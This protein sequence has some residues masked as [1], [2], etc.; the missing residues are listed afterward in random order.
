MTE[1]ELISI[2]KSHRRDSIGVADGEL[3]SERA[4]ALDHYHGR[5]YGNEV[6]G[7]SQVVSR[8]LSETVDWALPTVL[9]TFLQS[10]TL[11]AFDPVGPEDEDAADQEAQYTNH[12]MLKDNNGFM[13][14]HDA[15]KDT[16]I[17]KNGYTKRIWDD[18]EKIEEGE[19]TGLTMDQVVQLIQKKSYGGA[20]VE[21]IGAEVREIEIPGMPA[22]NQAQAI[23]TPPTIE[24][25]DLRLRTKCKEGKLLWMA[26]PTEEIRVSKKC[27]GT[28]Q[29]SPFTEHVTKKTRTD[30]I[31]MGMDEDFVNSLPAFNEDDNDSEKYARDSVTDESDS[32]NG[33]SINDRSMD[34]IEFC[35]AYIKVDWDK[36]GRAE[37]RKVVTV[38]DR[39]PP[40]SQWNEQIY[41]VPITGYSMKRVPHRHVGESF[42]DELKDLQEIFTTLKRQLND[43]VYFSNAGEVVINELA[44]VKDFMTR[45]P[46]GLKRTKGTS[47]PQQN[48]MQLV[49]PAIVGDL[50]PVFDFYTKSKEVRTGIRPGSDMDPDILR[51]STKGAFLEHLNRASQK[52]ELLTRMLAETGVKEDFQQCHAMLQRHQDR[53]RMVQLRGKWVE[54]NPSE[55][56]ERTNLT[57]RVGLGTGNE[58][59]KRQKLLLLTQ[60]QQQT[61]AAITAPA[62][63]YAKAHAL[64]SDVVKTM[65]FDSS[66]KYSIAPG[67]PEYQEVK[68]TPPPPNPDMAKVQGQ[69]Q[70]EQ[71]R[72]QMQQQTDQ[73][74]QE[75]EARQ[76]AAKMENEKQLALFRAQLEAQ[77]ERER[78]KWKAETDMLIARMN[79][80]AKLDAAQITAQTTLTAQQESASDNAAQD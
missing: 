14:L 45:T 78:M 36:D 12:V 64:F 26:V 30:L 40:G 18:S 69:Q 66:D 39:I 46:G 13:V 56:K 3:S 25:V 73:M 29:D 16:M 68:N 47:P 31:E 65:G 62:P 43:N 9:R 19:W 27:R 57:A 37:L 60:L 71:M 77:L 5:P 24:V 59:E 10:G 49:T 53:S 52:I 44:N 22:L 17:L 2:I 50:L 1:N 75:W 20:E 74:R 15:I 35:E 55:W 8:D 63:I 4:E 28:L 34:E 42:D 21:V 32:V 80:A 33:Q 54:V 7:R 70:L 38:A 67:S 51:E 11:G 58:E 76:Q 48:V 72:M 41:A 6:T 79:N 61:M 23:Q